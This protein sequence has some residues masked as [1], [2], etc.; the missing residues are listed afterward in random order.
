M[1]KTLT[2]APKLPDLVI[3]KIDFAPDCRTMISIKNV[4][5][6]EIL[7]N[8]FNGVNVMR[9]ID[10]QSKGWFR[11]SEADPSGAVRL[12][13]GQVVWT[14]FAEFKAKI[15]VN[16]QMSNLPGEKLT[17]NNAGNA[18]VPSRCTEDG[19]KRKVTAPITLPGTI[20]K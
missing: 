7:A 2:C 6:G 14:D 4:G 10:G 11:L 16:Y 1:Q 9:T 17:T 13:G 20:R 12:P 8:Y 15:G 5:D 19:S 18:N 3:E